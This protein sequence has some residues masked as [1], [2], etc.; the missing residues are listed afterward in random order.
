MRIRPPASVVVPTVE[1]REDATLLARAGAEHEVHLAQTVI[2]AGFV[3]DRN[4]LGF[5]D[6][7]HLARRPVEPNDGRVVRDRRDLQHLRLRDDDVAKAS[8][9]PEGGRSAP[10][11]QR[12][13]MPPAPSS[14]NGTSLV[15]SLSKSLR[16]E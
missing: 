13:T 16:P 3:L 7:A 2:V 15:P 6:Q 11:A 10:R 1:S 12:A 9:D 8:D 14:T 4:V 5:V